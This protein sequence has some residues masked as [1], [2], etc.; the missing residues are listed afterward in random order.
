MTNRTLGHQKPKLPTTTTLEETLRGEPERCLL[1]AKEIC[2]LQPA[3]HS[4]SWV[5]GE[6]LVGSKAERRDSR[7]V[8]EEKE[9]LDFVPK[10]DQV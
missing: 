9:L 7:D 4:S 6:E 8:G 5:S 3:T 10:L 2:C 1:R